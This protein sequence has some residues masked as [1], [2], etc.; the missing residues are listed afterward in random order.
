MDGSRKWICR[1]NSKAASSKMSI[2]YGDESTKMQ[3]RE[4]RQLKLSGD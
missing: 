4:L 2:L 1:R 3:K